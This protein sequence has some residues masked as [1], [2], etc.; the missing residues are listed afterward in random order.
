[1]NPT[2]SELYKKILKKCLKKL[3]DAFILP[4]EKHST[5]NTKIREY[6]I[7]NSTFKALFL[8][9]KFCLFKKFLIIFPPLV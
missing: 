4:R 1:M 7:K 6:N 9:K 5:K 8:Q 3:Y 2:I